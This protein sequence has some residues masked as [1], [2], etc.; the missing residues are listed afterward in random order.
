M[1]SKIANLEMDLMGEMLVDVVQQLMTLRHGE[2]P[3]ANRNHAVFMGLCWPP[4]DVHRLLS[5]A[6][7]AA[8]LEEQGRQHERLRINGEARH[9]GLSAKE[10]KRR[11]SGRALSG[12]FFQG[13]GGS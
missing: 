3:F 8:I 9:G 4:T 13:G 1:Q 5:T 7:R 2:F 6:M 11:R 10:R 12:G